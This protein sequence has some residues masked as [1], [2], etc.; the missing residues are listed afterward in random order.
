V[1]VALVG[2]VCAW[3]ADYLELE[4]LVVRVVL[5]VVAVASGGFGVVMY[6]VAWALIPSADSPAGRPGSWPWRARF[7]G[8]REAL[9]IALL[10]VGAILTL[11]HAGL[12]LGSQVVLPLVAASCGLALILRQAGGGVWVP[13]DALRPG[14]GRAGHA[15]RWRYWPRVAGASLIVL[16]AFLVIQQAGIWGASRKALGGIVVIVVALGLVFG[17]WFLRLARSLADERSERI[18]S[19]ERA[20]VAAHLHDSVLQTLTL[21]QRR[22]DDPREVAGLARSQER[23][24]RDWLFARDHLPATDSLATALKQAAADVEAIHRVRIEVVTVGDCPLDEALEAMTAA[25]REALTNAAKFAGEDR[26]DLYAEVTDER[27]QVFVRDRGVGF[28]PAAI[29][30][31]R[32]GVRQ[33]IVD[34]MRRHGGRAVVNSAPGR[35]AEIEL[36]MEHA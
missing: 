3:L 10:V 4:P 35:G 19:Q 7:A 15:H 8:W 32:C 25:A 33:S 23:E 36:V 28:D 13:G 1:E 27:A 9:G 11:H 17:P 21:I 30:P 29:P 18:R 16:A 22:A 14:R 24:L 5:V 12:W 6:P 34:R 20:E 31:D 2:G 26:I